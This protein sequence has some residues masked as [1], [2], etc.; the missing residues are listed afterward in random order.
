MS[1][2]TVGNILRRNGLEPTPIRQKGTTWAEF[3]RSQKSV[4]AATDFFTVEV[5][6]LKGIVT[7]YCLFF[8]KIGTREVHLAGITPYAQNTWMKQIARNLT[9]SGW[10]FLSG[11]KHLIHDG[12]GAFSPSFREIIGDAGIDPLR[13]PPRSPNLNAFAERWVRSVKEECLSKVI[14]IGEASLRNAIEEYLAY[15]HAE[16]NHQGLGNTIPFP[17]KQDQIGYRHGR[18]HC[19]ERL[20]G[21][22]KYYRRAG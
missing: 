7:F 17:R 13:L 11:M 8:I 2:Q 9:M 4:L 1:D 19:F 15:F 10:G 20:G 21:L 5:L 22:L 6:T 14:L 18:I 16:R 3:I 12:D